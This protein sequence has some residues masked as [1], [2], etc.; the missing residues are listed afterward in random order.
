MKI[1]LSE[2]ISKFGGELVG[3]DLEISGVAPT[4]L[5]SS[6]QITFLTDTK[7]KDQINSLQ[8]SAIIVA[9]KDAV[10][11]GIAK[12]ITENPYW[13]FSKVSQ[14]FHPRR[15]VKAGIKPTVIIGD[16]VVIG[17]NPAIADYVV[18]GENVTIGKNCQIHPHV[19]IGDNINIGDNVIIYPNVT[20]YDNVTVGNNCVFHSGVVLGS[21][22]F[23]N[24]SDRQKHWSRIPQIGGVIIGDSV[25]IGANT[26]VDCGTFKP[27]I[28][29][30][31]AVIDNLVQIAH[32]V[33]IGAHSGIAACV[34]IAGST[35]IGRHCQ[36]GGGSGI[37]GH[38]EIT[39]YTVIGAAT[40]VS[41]SITK[42]DLY[43]ATYPFSTLKEWAKNA[44][45]IK[46]L[47]GM[48]QRIKELETQIKQINGDNNNDA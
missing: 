32:N 11:I 30:D 29:E 38:I 1:K 26:T 5:V 10:G 28:I 31:G 9:Q 24:A 12:I 48:Y 13:Y 2:L 34:G 25:D 17:N 15:M 33:V 47:H 16:N 40:G 45:H 39:D 3:D 19:V 43:F 21:D 46:H 37:T 14:L 7:Y 6:G 42:P 4:N 44:V 8:A 22:G 23:G 27:T 36:I 20:I 18:V 35:K 41:K